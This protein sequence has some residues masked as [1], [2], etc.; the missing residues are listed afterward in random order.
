MTLRV[1]T[2]GAG[3]VSGFHLAAWRTL[4]RVD[5]VAICD[6][7]LSRA[8]ARASEF[9]IARCYS[10]AQEMLEAERPDVLDI[11]APVG[12]HGALCR[13]AAERG[14]HILCQKPLGAS[15]QEAQ[16]TVA[17]VG[18]RVRLMV[19]ENWRFRPQ[20]RQI[21]RWLDEGAL[22]APVSC[23]MRVRSSGLLPDAA[24]RRPQLLR[25]PFFASLERLL[26]GEVLVHHL[27]LLRWLIGPLEVV[28]ARAGRI[29]PI[30][31]GEDHALIMLA[32]ASAYAVLEGSLVAAGAPAR[33]SEE[34]ELLGTAGTVHFAGDRL[35]L[36]GKREESVVIDTDAAY[37]ASYAGAIAHFVAALESD[38][39]FETDARD[40]LQTLALVE[41]AYRACSP[42]RSL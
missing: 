18:A 7:D 33:S 1:A 29:C 15:L 41:A 35:R 16:N 3:W 5:L 14:A 4:P 25:Q 28:A 36:A 9:G 37:R 17:E 10:S 23:S 20:Y 22:G 12:S 40:N 34:F 21:R 39:P 30:A 32:G 38:T 19:H 26:I 2:A 24:G 8:E 11:A 27:D 6:P 42:P 31:R 13:L